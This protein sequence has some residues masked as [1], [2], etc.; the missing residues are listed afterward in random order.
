M[1]VILRENI[2]SLGYVGDLVKVSPGYARNYLLPRKL[3]VVANEK[4][5]AQIEHHKKALE[6]KREAILADAKAMAEKL[7]E[8]SC[9]ITRKIGEKGQFFGSVT[10]NDVAEALGKAGYKVEKSK[11]LLKEPIKTL[12]VHNVDV[13]LAP[14]IY[15]TIKVWVAEEK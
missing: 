11:I 1:L 6:K 4:N 2:E 12:G 14:E 5:K 10:A 7:N 9:T 8:V 3:V 13:K 15:A